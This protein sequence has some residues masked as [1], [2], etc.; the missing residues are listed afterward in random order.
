MSNIKMEVKK[1]DFWTIDLMEE[2]EMVPCENSHPNVKTLY[3]KSWSV[4]EHKKRFGAIQRLAVQLSRIP[5]QNHLNIVKDLGSDAKTFLATY[6]SNE[7]VEEKVEK[8]EKV[9]QME[10]IKKKIEVMET[11]FRI[12]DA[13]P[14]FQMFKT[15]F[16]ESTSKM[17][18]V[19]EAM[20]DEHA[21]S[22]DALF[23]MIEPEDLYY[24]FAS[25]YVLFLEP[26]LTPRKR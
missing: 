7:K 9:D 11:A 21:I 8:V 15:F 6:S 3:I 12:S 23:N 10:E 1:I 13:E 22:I 17:V 26:L 18:F 4:A 24:L 19:H 2:V 14:L 16:A 5:M 25:F 20:E